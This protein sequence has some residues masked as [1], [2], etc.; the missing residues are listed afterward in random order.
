MEGKKEG[1]HKRE[2]KRKG[3]K[4]RRKR[5]KLICFM[6]EIFFQ[7]NSHKELWL[8][9]HS[10]WK[11]PSKAVKPFFLY[12]Y[13]CLMNLV[14]WFSLTE[15]K[16]TPNKFAYISGLWSVSF[17]FF[18]IY[19]APV[20]VCIWNSFH[21]VMLLSI[22]SPADSAAFRGHGTFNRWSLV[23]ICHRGGLGF[24]FY[25]LVSFYILSLLA[26]SVCG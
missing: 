14:I 18:F 23:D 2:S 1:R 24:G 6:P 3:R 7:M 11:L 10:V 16:L 20:V 21:R 12:K 13:S 8:S 22:W 17:L 9:F 15:P 5:K 26:F 4:K 19:L 25:S